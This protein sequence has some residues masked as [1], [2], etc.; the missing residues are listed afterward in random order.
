MNEQEFQFQVDLGS[1]IARLEQMVADPSS[2]EWLL[3]RV[4]ECDLPRMRQFLAPWMREAV[5][6]AMN[7]TGLI[8]SGHVG[9]GNANVARSNNA[10]N[11]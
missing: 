1:L 8:S 11:D 2:R 10:G 4:L 3:Y 9:A 5:D 6:K 7:D